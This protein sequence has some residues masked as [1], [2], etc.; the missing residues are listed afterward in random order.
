L[1]RFQ[2]NEFAKRQR[3]AK[4]ALEGHV[5]SSHPNGQHI[6]LRLPEQW[7]SDDLVASAK[8]SG[9]QITGY[10]PFVLDT[11]QPMPYVRISLGA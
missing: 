5:Y 9:V 10:K 1:I 2:V 7:N 4:A 8:R 6:W 3:I 11:N